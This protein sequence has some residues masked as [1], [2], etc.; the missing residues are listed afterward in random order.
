MADRDPHCGGDRPDL[1]RRAASL[2]RGRVH[3]AREMGNGTRS[4]AARRRCP[5]GV[6]LW[7]AAASRGRDRKS[8][9]LNSSHGYNSHAVF[10]LK[11]KRG[12]LK[13]D[14]S[15]TSNRTFRNLELDLSLW[16]PP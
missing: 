12:I 13:L 7:A 11:K 9:R 10:R 3:R 14:E 6:Y 2:W 4:A 5:S 15:C 16:R 8:T 1:H